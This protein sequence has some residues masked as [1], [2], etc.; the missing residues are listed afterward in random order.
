MKKTYVFLC[1]FIFLAFAAMGQVKKSIIE[2]LDGE[3]WWGGVVALGAQMPFRAELKEYDLSRDNHNNQIVPLFISSKGRYLWSE[4]PFIFNI[5]EGN[6]II[7][8]EYEKMVAVVAGSTLRDAYIAAKN[9]HFPPRGGV[10]A[11]MFF[12]KPQYNTWIELMYNQ[13]QD[14]ILDY[15]NKVIKHNFPTGVFMVDDNWQKYYGNFEFKPDKFPDP[16]K[17][18]E[19]LHKKEFKIMLWISP[20]VSADSPEYRELSSKGYLLRDRKS[21]NNA[22]I[23]W[24]NGVSAVYDTT[25]PKAMSHFKEQLFKLQ[26]EYGVD[27]F[28]FDAGDVSYMQGNYLFF[29]DGADI[30]IFSQRWAEL[31]LDFPYNELR[32][33]WK[34]GGAPLVQR[35]GD[36]NYSWG[37]CALLIPDMI[38]AGL[39]GHLYTCPDMIGGGQ[40][41]S[42]LNIDATEFDQE[43]IVRSCQL[44]ALMP[45]MQFSVAPWRILDQKHLDICVK[46]AKLHEDMGEYILKEAEKSAL[47]GEPI[48]RHLEYSYPNQG[49]IECKDQ[50]M[51]GDDYLVAPMVKSG[52]KRRVSLPKGE[53]IDDLGVSFIGP[54]VMDIDVPLERLPY[55][56]VVRK[57]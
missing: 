46:F 20:F 3:R 1:F 31:G 23:T 15:A 51:L 6:L 40:F 10:P 8:S 35:L 50:F 33:S 36:K 54:V 25:N 22:M 47:S 2:P 14:D 32:T 38:S 29:E 42:F 45:M 12:S 17:M 53:W 28:K 41:G 55:Y 56:R 52:S 48:L 27:G 37:A 49:F 34:L 5:K 39:L 19:Q 13:N 30:N 44:H 18:I 7:Q 24:W 16:K 26:S 9:N 43:L 4:K 11:P 57:M 21:G